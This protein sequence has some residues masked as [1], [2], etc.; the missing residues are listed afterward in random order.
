MQA[1]HLY[2]EAPCTCADFCLHSFR[3]QTTEERDPRDFRHPYPLYSRTLLP[4]VA[5][6]IAAGHVARI[7]EHREY[8]CRHWGEPLAKKWKKKKPDQK[9]AVLK[10]ADPTLFSR[11][12]FPLQEHT[13]AV[14]VQTFAQVDSHR[15]SYLLGYLNVESLSKDYLKLLGLIQNRVLFDPAD[16]A[17]HDN[18]Q[19]HFPWVECKL[20]TEFSPLC[21]EL[22]PSEYGILKPWSAIGT[23]GGGL[24][25]FPRAKL[26]L[27]AQENLYRFLRNVTE[28]IVGTSMLANTSGSVQVDP[29]RVDFVDQKTQ[30]LWSSYLN[31]PVCPPPKFEIDLMI[32]K[33][34]AQFKLSSD[35]LWDLQTDSDYLRR[36]IG[37]Y[38]DGLPPNHPADRIYNEVAL[39]VPLGV[40]NFFS[41]NY[42][43]RA[44]RH[45]KWVHDHYAD[46]VVLGQPLP[47]AYERVLQELEYTLDSHIIDRY[48]VLQYALSS[49]PRFQDYYLKQMDDNG[50]R[51]IAL[52]LPFDGLLK[53][54]PLFYILETI[55]SINV[56]RR[57]SCDIAT[58]W[59]FLQDYLAG[60]SRREASFLDEDLYGMYN[61]FAAAHELRLLFEFQMPKPKRNLGAKQPRVSCSEA[62]MEKTGT[63][64]QIFREC[65]TL[66]GTARDAD[67]ILRRHAPCIVVPIQQSHR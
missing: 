30:E 15:N 25:G 20:K 32:S 3:E 14:K 51:H 62:N 43:L 29:F 41:W 24:L 66:S 64:H 40:W 50:K 11:Q 53:K 18:L 42:I 27:E 10:K 45:V 44:G 16:W 59:A 47:E 37:L 4:A 36:E 9:T 57:G 39:M 34:E 52:L 55:A 56:A 7:K 21:M 38:R 49:R 23:H 48:E 1:Q 54:E 12:W 60:A 2:F 22:S 13:S 67:D 5:R 28:Q 35:H 61:G 19:L 8:I 63:Y 31:M 33:A 6:N 17:L 26:L 65:L 58:R 46:S